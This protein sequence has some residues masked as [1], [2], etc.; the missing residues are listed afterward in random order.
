MDTSIGHNFRRIR[1]N[2]GLEILDVS[3]ETG[4][5]ESHIAQLER[6]KRR[7]SFDCM[8]DLMSYYG[9]EPNDIFGVDSETSSS[10]EGDRSYEDR[11]QKLTVKDKLKAKKAIEA[12]LQVFEEGVE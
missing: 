12:I 1:E 6:D 4:Y 11:L 3:V 9:C 8:M 10:G 5:S 7:P 2:L